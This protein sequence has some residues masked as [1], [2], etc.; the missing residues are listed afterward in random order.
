MTDTAP[1]A[2]REVL[3]E[4]LGE[5]PWSMLEAHAKRD[6]LIVVS[7]ELDLLDVAEA[8]AQ[9]DGG[10]VAAWMAQGQ[11]TKPGAAAM[12]MYAAEVARTW[13]FVIVAPFVI[14]HDKAPTT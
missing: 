6:G 9:D 5:A 3:A 8:L 11:L 4:G 14:V 2:L 7:P 1:K 10:A 13:P 12:V